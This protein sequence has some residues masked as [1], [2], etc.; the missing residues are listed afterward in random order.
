MVDSE[1]AAFHSDNRNAL[2][3]SS[4]LHKHDQSNAVRGGMGNNE[5]LWTAEPRTYKLVTPTRSA[6]ARL[7]AIHTRAHTLAMK[8]A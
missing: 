3:M 5:L 1:T 8:C 7:P 4:T 6:S 2:L